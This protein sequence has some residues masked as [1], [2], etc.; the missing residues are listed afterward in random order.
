MLP[1]I[2]R[3]FRELAGRQRTTEIDIALADLILLGRFREVVGTCYSSFSKLSA[4]LGNLP[5]SEI[6]ALVCTDSPDPVSRAKGI[7]LRVNHKQ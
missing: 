2:F 4:L 5:Y 1:E 7:H 6:Y 3:D